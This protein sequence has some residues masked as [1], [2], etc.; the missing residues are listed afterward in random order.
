MKTRVAQPMRRQLVD[1]RRRYAAAEST[2]LTEAHIIEQNEQDVWRALGWT[3]DLWKSWRVRVL[4]GAANVSREVKV[5]PRQ[6]LRRGQGWNGGRN[7]WAILRSS[8]LR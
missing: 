4:V 2:K 7:G 8:G 6:R 1:I 5:G 3:H